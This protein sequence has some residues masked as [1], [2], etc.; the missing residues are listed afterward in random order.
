MS[1][2][3]VMMR[4]LREIDKHINAGMT[5]DY[6]IPSRFDEG[7]GLSEKAI[8]RLCQE[9][10]RPDLIITVDCGVT[11]DNEIKLLNNMGV[12]VVV[13]DHHA[14]SD[15]YP[16]NCLL[17][18]PEA[19][20]EGSEDANLAGVGVALKLICVLCGRLGMPHI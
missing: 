18:D 14:K 2:T 3:A 13:T 1:S 4:G 12:D 10:Q 19:N 6:F 17:I 11:S 9:K 5:L 20:D 7:Y 8:K 16:Q 15:N